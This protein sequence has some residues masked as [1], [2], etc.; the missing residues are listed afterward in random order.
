MKDSK[1]RQ[2]HPCYRPEKWNHSRKASCCLFWTNWVSCIWIHLVAF[3]QC[4]SLPSGYDFEKSVARNIARNMDNKDQEERE[5]Y[6]MVFVKLLKMSWSTSYIWF[7][8]WGLLFYW[9]FF[10]VGRKKCREIRW[11][12]ILFGFAQLA[13]IYIVESLFFKWY[14]SARAVSWDYAFWFLFCWLRSL[15]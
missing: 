6:V 1:F 5:N 13:A 7:L 4:K 15:R 9:T 11:C 14:W 2:L 3:S 12:F 10:A 8:V